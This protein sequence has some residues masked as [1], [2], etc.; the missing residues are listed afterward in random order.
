M[1]LTTNSKQTTRRTKM[2]DSP[3]FKIIPITSIKDIQTVLEE[4]YTKEDI[5][6]A[7]EDQIRFDRMIADFEHFSNK[8][9][10]PFAPCGFLN[11]LIE[12]TLNRAYDITYTKIGKAKEPE[13]FVCASLHLKKCMELHQE[14]I[15]QLSAAMGDIHRGN[16]YGD[17]VDMVETVKKFVGMLNNV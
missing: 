13:P 16:V 9:V 2:T 5:Q 3:R 7:S 1:E 10:D 8:A 17:D 14:I 4:T 15:D 11:K 12:N 6:E